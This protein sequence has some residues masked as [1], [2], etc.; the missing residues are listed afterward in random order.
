[1]QCTEGILQDD[2]VVIVDEAEASRLH[3]KGHFGVP[4]SGGSLR[5][6]LLEA[7]YLVEKERVLVMA[8]PEAPE[9]TAGPAID[10]GELLSRA[11]KAIPSFEVRYSV[12][13][14]LRDRG[15]ILA[16]PRLLT[17]ADEK[18]ILWDLE[19]YSRGTP[20]GAGSR[21]DMRVFSISER[22]PLVLGELIERV[23]EASK[24]GQRVLIAL[25]DEE[26]D[27][28]YYE[29]ATAEPSGQMPVKLKGHYD[30]H[31]LEDRVVITGKEAHELYAAGFYGKPAP[32]SLQLSFLE[33]A[34]LLDRDVLDI[35]N[36]RTGKKVAQRELLKI[37]RDRQD[38][39]DERLR[40]YSDLRD[41]GMVVK[42]GFKYGTHFRVYQGDPSNT[43]AKYLMHA[44]PE[45]YASTWPELSR[46][47]R[48][49]HGVRKDILFSR[50]LG[51]EMEYIQFNRVRP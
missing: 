47:V 31:L 18:S 2:T 50:V 41:R 19:A 10:L 8:P 42:T 5:L 36:A 9:G 46:A 32:G 1:M 48:L 35:K 26:G 38:E 14:D 22:A 37:A 33:A 24:G 13:R 44:V 51:K 11:V 49:A 30:G 16:S 40:A 43:H 7:I 27:A 23:R 25:V 39:F 4:E 6:H 28:T 15:Y 17:R 3:N 21:P 34:Y 12:Y 29:V 45:D 20:P